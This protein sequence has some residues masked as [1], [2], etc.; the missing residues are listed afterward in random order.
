MEGSAKPTTNMS[1]YPEVKIGDICVNKS[2]RIWVCEYTYDP[3][4]VWS[5]LIT[6]TSPYLSGNFY[7]RTEIDNT[8]S[9]YI[10]STDTVKNDGTAG[11]VKVNN[12]VYGIKNVESGIIGTVKATDEEIEKQENNFKPIVPSSLKKAVETIGGVITNLKTEDK[13]SYVNALNEVLG[14]ATRERSWK[15]IRT[16]VVPSDEYLGQTVDGVEFKRG[17]ADTT[18]TGTQICRVEFTTDENGN[19]LADHDITNIHIMLTPA[20]TINFNQG[21]LDYNGI[22]LIYLYNMKANTAVRHYELPV[23]GSYMA[24]QTGLVYNYLNKIVGVKKIDKITF[25]GHERNSV[26]GEGT[27]LEVWAYGYWDDTEVISD[28]E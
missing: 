17:S 3:T 2:Y 15:K 10:K 16:I 8:L 6:A 1:D 23:G 4:V 18:S 21:F 5:E 12:G 22:H 24:N 27:K 11:V 19:S 28:A 14:Y 9:N 26:P 7:S 20:E 13:S 25:G